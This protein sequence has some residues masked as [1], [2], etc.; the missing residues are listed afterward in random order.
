MTH[1]NIHTDEHLVTLLRED[2][3]PA[4][5]ELYNRFFDSLFTKAYNFLRQDEAAKDC[6]QEVFIWLWQHR[7]T[8]SID[9]VNHY[10]HQAVRFQALKSLKA[11][12]T[13]ISL[14]DRLTHFTTTILQD[15]T[16]RYKELKEIIFA[17]IARL[18][19]L[20]GKMWNPPALAG[21]Y[22]IVRNDSEAAC[23]QLPLRPF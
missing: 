1:Q 4:F 17:I 14:D 9:H 11:Q 5:N 21:E 6:V 3:I 8:V 23:Y 7:H 16:L 15:D 19:A 2:N 12:R 18:P 20:K 22:L 13:T 10:L